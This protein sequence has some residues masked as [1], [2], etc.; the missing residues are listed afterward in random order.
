MN[1]ETLTSLATD[2]W[3]V[4]LPAVPI[5]GTAIHT[6]LRRVKSHASTGQYFTDEKLMSPPLTRP[7]YSD[8][9]AYVLAEMSD[10]AYFQ[11]EGQSGLVEDTVLRAKSLDLSTDQSVREFLEEFSTELIGG[12]RLNS[13]TFTAVLEASGFKLLG[14]IHVD[15]T[16]GFICK[17]NVKND[18]PYLVLAFRGT[19]K[20][21][22]DWLTN[23]RWI[24]TKDG[25]HTGF[26]EAFEIK[27]T[28]TTIPLDKWLRAS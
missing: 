22:S 16:Q 10:L 8:R 21:I 9:T 18:P 17:R 23:A 25:V 15:E 4:V 2:H 1:I 26:F 13:K 5:L 12:R 6:F 7:A 19:E 14:L 27:R 28:M 20:K 3:W 24:P 11:F